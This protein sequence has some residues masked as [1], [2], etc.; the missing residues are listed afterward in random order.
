MNKKLKHY[1]PFL[2]LLTFLF[3]FSQAQAQEFFPLWPSKRMP[4]TK[5][6]S[7]HDSLVNQ[8]YYQV[9]KPGLYAFFPSK[10]ENKG[11]AVIICPGGGYSHITYNWNGLQLAKWFNTMGINA[12]VLIYRLPNS[13]DLVNREEGPLQ[14][15]QRAVKLVRANAGNWDIDPHKVGVMGASAGGHLAAL[16]GTFDQDLSVIQDPVDAYSFI[17]DFSILVSPVISMGKNAHAGSKRNLLGDSPDRSL[18]QRYSPELNINSKTP[19]C[20]IAD[21]FND[22]VVKPI[23]SLLYYKGMLNE[24]ISASLHVFPQGAHGL[25]LRDNPGSANTWTYLCELWLNEMG[26]INKLKK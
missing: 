17:P 19:P 25:A 23:N 21:S 10:E 13:P 26:F 9:S 6:I 20:F 11:S 2:S 14:D 1:R 15:A 5:G 24:R 4:N 22:P 8:R 7:I 16:L 18:E 12:F 3:V